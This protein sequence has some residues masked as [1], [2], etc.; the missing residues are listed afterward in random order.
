MPYQVFYVE[1]AANEPSLQD[2]P[3]KEHYKTKDK[4][5]GRIRSLFKDNRYHLI[6]LAHETKYV[7]SG[8]RLQL[9]LDTGPASE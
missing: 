5:L 1:R 9:E 8:F 4:A 2:R 7:L 3:R 6:L